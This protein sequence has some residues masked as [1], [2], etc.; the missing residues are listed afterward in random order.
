MGSRLTYGRRTRGWVT[1]SPK[2]RSMPQV[3]YCE[4]EG[5]NPYT[6]PALRATDF[7]PRPVSAGSRHPGYTADLEDSSLTP[8]TASKKTTKS[9]GPAVH[10][11][12]GFLSMYPPRA[13]ASR[14]KWP[15]SAGSA[16]RGSQPG[17]Q[18]HPGD[19]MMRVRPASPAAADLPLDHRSPPCSA[20]SHARCSSRSEER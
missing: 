3:W 7:N 5:A 4:S 20:H 1:S 13:M 8:Q 15:E 17:G 10:F 2:W 14:G 16:A 11:A 12:G 9:P 19:A 18:S 6:E